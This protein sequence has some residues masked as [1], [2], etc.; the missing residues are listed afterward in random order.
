MVSKVD[1]DAMRDTNRKLML[2]ALFNAQQTSRSEIA[3]QIAL[4]KSTVT[5]IYRDVEADGYIEELG[6]GT[7]SKAGGRKPKLIRFNRHYG[8]IVSFDLGRNHLRYL[9]ARITGEVISRGQMTVFGMRYADYKRA[10]LSYVAQLGDMQTDHGLIGIGV[11]IHGVVEDNKVRYTPFHT[12]LVNEDMAKDLEEALHVPVILENEANLAAIYLRDYHDYDAAETFQNFTVVNIHNGIG[13]GVIQNGRLFR[14]LHGE[15]GEIGRQVVLNND[16]LA[17]G[18]FDSTIHIEDLY[19]EDAM[20]SRLGVLKGQ[21]EITRE[22]FLSLYMGGDADAKSLIDEWVHAI[23]RT[24]YNLAQ[25][26]APEAVFVHSRFIAGT[27]ELLDYLLET[28]HKIEPESATPLYFAKKSVNRATLSGGVAMVTRSLLD[29]MG[30]E[31]NF[32]L[33]EEDAAESNW[34]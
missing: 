19:S 32:A 22:D 14:G 18:E 16:Q 25:Y 8:Y 34:L 30:Y 20:L 24:I 12:E 27:P 3:E 26:A 28:Y 4:H 23:C 15:A 17:K 13:A 29:M 1:Q 31:L 5:T 21:E 6:E 7:V 33:E 10:M 2:Q 11:A 9:V